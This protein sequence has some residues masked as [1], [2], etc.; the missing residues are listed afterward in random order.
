MSVFLLD[1]G[2]RAAIAQG[3]SDHRFAV[4]R[5]EE[6]IDDPAQ[7]LLAV[8][9]DAEWLDQALAAA[10]LALARPVADGAWRGVGRPLAYQDTVSCA[11]ARGA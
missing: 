1:A 2:S 3:S 11:T 6:W 5:G 7:P 8:A 10:G 4:A 9:F